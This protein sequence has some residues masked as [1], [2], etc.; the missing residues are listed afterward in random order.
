MSYFRSIISL[1][2]QQTKMNRRIRI[3]RQYVFHRTE[4]VGLGSSSLASLAGWDALCTGEFWAC[5]LVSLVFRSKVYVVMSCGSGAD[6]AFACVPFFSFFGIIVCLKA[7]VC[8]S[9]GSFWIRKEANQMNVFS[10]CL[11]GSTRI[12]QLPPHHLP[13]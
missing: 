11:D 10:I 6:L 5:V 1:N 4:T 12:I 13:S 3:P 9:C 2:A 7:Y 8:L